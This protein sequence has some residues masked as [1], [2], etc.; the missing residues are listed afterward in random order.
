MQVDISQKHNRKLQQMYGGELFTKQPGDRVINLSNCEIDDDLLSIFDLGMNCHLKT[1]YDKNRTKI[2]LEKLNTS[3]TNY[4][5]NEKLEFVDEERF[6]TELKRFG[7]REQNNF[8]RDLITKQQYEKIKN[9]NKN[10]EIITRKADKSNTFVI[11]NMN[12]YEEKISSVLT[13][14]S[15]FLKISKDPSNTIKSDIN[16]IIS[17]INSQSKC[18]I[19]KL[20]GH[21]VPGY[22]YG[23]PKIHKCLQ[24][25]PIRP[26]VSQ[27]GTVTY[28]TAKFINKL[29]SPY[30]NRK[31]MVEST[32]EFMEITKTIRNPKLLASLDVE[33][34]FT[35]VPVA[36]TINIILESAYNHE[37][38][39]APAI[40]KEML[41]KLL[42]ICTTMTP[43]KAPNGD[44]YQQINGVSMG[45]PL[46]PTMANFYMSHLEN[47]IFEKNPSLKPQ[48]YCRYV[49][50]IFLVLNNFHELQ[51]LNKAFEHNSVLSFTHEIET[52]K[53]I[54]FLDVHISRNNES[55][56]TG[57]FTKCTSSGDCLNYNSI[58]PDRYKTSVIKNFLYRA[59]AI[60]SSWSLFH[61]EVTRIRQVLCN[62][63][64]P[65]H[66]VEKEIDKFISRKLVN[67]GNQPNEN[68]E[69]VVAL[70]YQNQMTSRYKQEEA[71]LRRIVENNVQ[72]KSENYKLKLNIYYRNKKLK[73]LFIKNNPHKTNEIYNVV[74]KYTCNEVPCNEAQLCYIGHTTTTIKDRFRQHTSIKK[75]HREHHDS[76]ITGKHMLPNVT[77]LQK[78]NDRRDL[79]IMEALMIK[80]FKPV[81]NIQTDD[82]NRT[83]KIF[84]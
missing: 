58:C 49:D 26:I 76:N 68:S 32:F 9:F 3:I 14:T 84:Q 63:N 18:D 55:V 38:M 16:N 5:K 72:T 27:V 22:M 73:S 28:T 64:F 79:I 30:M 59:Y 10:S 46:G 82:F 31:Y 35:N 74:Y 53:K 23:N 24:N 45:T 61:Q 62:N 2:E 29:I 69:E 81:I 44:L 67:I 83:L 12:D 25:P 75:H 51:N 33:S 70:Y 50:D 1:K 77:V 34:L 52:K 39:T 37:T 40:P 19:P 4:V 56:T 66:I 43:F 48:V 36:E 60:C 8:S 15:K 13:D 41:R 6:K 11:M 65:S 17:I 20:S 21:F 71:Y 47:E 57:V 54:P 7:L 80:E 78:C 42:V